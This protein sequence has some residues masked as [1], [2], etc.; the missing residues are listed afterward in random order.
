MTISMAEIS[1][2]VMETTNKLFQTRVAVLGF[3][4]RVLQLEGL[5]QI[6]NSRV[7]ELE[8]EVQQLK[9][10]LRKN[11]IQPSTVACDAVSGCVPDD[12]PAP[13]LYHNQP[14]PQRD[15]M[16]HMQRGQQ[17]SVDPSERNG[18]NYGT[19]PQ[20]RQQAVGG[21]GSSCPICGKVDFRSVGELEMHS[22]KCTDYK[23]ASKYR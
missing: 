12:L 3:K 8:H 20:L 22:A 7:Q 15:Y 10:Q 1:K 21:P 2:E 5:L 9:D 16:S 23:D 19:Y 18:F 11:G 13:I 6:S 14:T 17:S 4:S